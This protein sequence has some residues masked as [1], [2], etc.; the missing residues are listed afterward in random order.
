MI[1]VVCWLWS[2]PQYRFNYLFRYGAEHVNKL[3]R[4]VCRNLDMPFEFCCVTDDPTGIDEAVRIIP[5]W[6]DLAA[7]GGCYRRLKCFSPEMKDIIGDRFVSIDLDSVVVGD[8]TPLFAR[9]D[10]FIAWRNVDLHTPYCGSMFMMDAGARAEVWHDFDPGVSPL[11]GQEKGHIGTDQ[12]WFAARLG[13]D[14]KVWTRKDG[15]LSLRKNIAP[16][17]AL[18]GRAER[19]G[20]TIGLPEGARIVFFHGA[21]DPSQPEVQRN[22]SWIADHWV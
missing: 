12:A 1:R 4:G 16:H 9:D 19:Q 14:E 21:S 22:H 5:I 20:K 17:G 7:M 18:K 10:P 2:D 13:P 15:V 6:D 11:L 3:Y 8:L